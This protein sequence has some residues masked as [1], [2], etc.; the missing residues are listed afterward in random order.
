M[1]WDAMNPEEVL[2]Y[3]QTEARTPLE[4]ALLRAAEELDGTETI[5]ELE[6]EMAGMSDVSSELSDAEEKIDDLENALAEIR[7]VLD[8]TDDGDTDAERL[9]RVRECLP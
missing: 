8:S 4:I 2:H 9:E 5:S 6:S 7:K 3:A 1:N